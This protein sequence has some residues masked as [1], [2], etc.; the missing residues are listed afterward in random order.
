M[1]KFGKLKGELSRIS[2]ISR[3]WEELKH[4]DWSYEKRWSPL[5]KQK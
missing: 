1:G 3:M 4:E 5:Q 2:R